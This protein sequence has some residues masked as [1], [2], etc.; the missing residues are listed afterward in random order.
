MTKKFS[1]SKVLVTGGTR[2]IGF[3]IANSFLTS[4]A[5][6]VITGTAQQKPSQVDRGIEYEQLVID[7]S[8]NWQN[9]IKSIVQK[10]PDINVL[11]NNAGVNRVNIIHETHLEDIERLLLMNLIVPMHLVSEISK[12]MIIQDG[13]YILNIG[14]VFGVVSKTGR[15]SYT[16]SKS[17]LIGATKTMAI[18]LAPYNI[19]VNCVSP[20]FV[21]TELTRTVLGEKGMQ[22]MSVRIPLRRLAKT[23]EITPIILFLCSSDNTYITGQ[24]IVVDGGFTL[25]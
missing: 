23:S 16:A 9:Q 10:H 22:E 7:Q 6:V 15:A 14:S 20:G 18:D 13:G 1:N 11:I 24:N 17:G 2:G 3:E 12:N 5:S 21:D 25:E 4:G 8:K 19:F